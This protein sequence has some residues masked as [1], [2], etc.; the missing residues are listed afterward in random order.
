MTDEI[1]PAFSPDGTRLAFGQAT[2]NSED[3]YSGDGALVITDLSAD[4]MRTATTTIALDGMP[5]PP[6]GIWSAD[7]RWVAFGVGRATRDAD[8]VWVVDTQSDDIRRL[9]GLS[10]TDLDWAPD[11]TELAIASDGVVLYSVTADETRP[12][13]GAGAESVAWSPDGRTI[14]FIRTPAGLGD[15]HH[16]LWLMDADGT[17]ERIL[18][19]EIRCHAW[20]GTGVVTRRRPHRLP[21]PLRIFRPMFDGSAARRRSRPAH[22]ERGRSAEPAGH[23]GGHPTTAD[24][25]TR[26]A[27]HV[28]VSLECHVVA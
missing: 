12:L 17:N 9:T 26:R 8:E 5:H 3:G 11:A 2:G 16:D 10:A 21:T 23:S 14:A 1:C 19:P 6:C 22:R 24:H 7:G 20:P 18:V 28:V 15:T 25:W 13:G 27:A 4:G